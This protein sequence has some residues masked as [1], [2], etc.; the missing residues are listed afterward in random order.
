MDR[1]HLVFGSICSP[2][3]VS[4]SLLG[5]WNGWNKWFSSKE[6][7]LMGIE[8]VL[9]LVEKVCGC[10]ATA[11]MTAVQLGVFWRTFFSRAFGWPQVRHK[12]PWC[13]SIN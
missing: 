11:G 2:F 10:E 1:F 7:D 13:G 6:R 3:V 4:L 12:D 9:L 5:R 8:Q